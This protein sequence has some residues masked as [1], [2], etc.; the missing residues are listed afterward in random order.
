MPADPR[1][2]LAANA[3]AG[4]ATPPAPGRRPTLYVVA[5]SHLD[6]QWRWTLRD[7][8]RDFLP[9]T[10][11]ENLALFARFPGYVLSF[12]GAFRYQLLRD[13]YPAEWPRLLAAVA[14][15]RWHPAGAALEAFDCN[16]PA[17]ESIVRQ[18]LYGQAF[19]ERHFGRRCA[20]LFLPDCFG[21]PQILPTLAVH[22]GLRGFSSQKLVRNGL[23]RS[24]FGVPF[25]VGVWEG[26]DGSELLAALDPGGYG[27]PV[28]GDL[29]FDAEIE[30]QVA[31]LEQTGRPPVVFRYTG[32]GDKGGGLPVETLRWLER[33]AAPGARI[34]V[35]N[36][37]SERLFL[38]LA[39]AEIARLPRYRGELLLSVH[40]TGCY[41]S[42]AAM[43]RW[44]RRNEQLAA[45]AETAAVAASWLGA[46]PYPR[47]R[48]E[49]AWTRFLAHQMHDD[50]TG[51]S[52]PAAYR[53]SWR[54]EALAGNELAGVLAH[55]LAAVARGLDTRG[56]GR[57]LVVFN[58]LPIARQEL[59]EVPLPPALAEA[60]GVEAFDDEERPLATQRTRTAA[61]EPAV[62][63]R[64]GVPPLSFSVLFLVATELGTA[65][66]ATALGDGA[67]VRAQVEGLE[68]D[69][70]R[71]ELDRDGQVAQLFDR[72]LDR[73]ILAAPVRLELLADRS[74]KFPA[75]EIQHRDLVA[76]PRALARAL[77]PARV[78][79]SGPLRGTLEL[80]L[81][82][83]GSRCRQRL[84]LVAAGA[85][86]GLEVENELDWASRGHLL[87]A[88]FDLAVERAVGTWDLGLGWIERGVAS[89]RL[90]EVPAQQW[91]GLAAGD[92]T[93]GAAIAVDCKQ[94]WDRPAS[95]TLRLSLVRTPRVGR[96][97]RPQGWQDIG[98]HR[99]TWRLL[100]HAG[101]GRDG[102]L[103]RAAARLNQ[104][105]RG[106]WVEPHEGRFGRRLSL[107]SVEPPSAM[108]Q[109]LKLAEC[110]EEWIARLADLTGRGGTVR[111][112]IVAA[113]EDARAVDGCERTPEPLAATASDASTSPSHRPR[114]AV[115]RLG[116]DS[117]A[118]DLPPHGLATAALRVAPPACGPLGLPTQRTWPLPFDR[119][120]TSANGERADP[121]FDDRGRAIPAE[122]FPT[123]LDWGTIRFAL[124]PG[125]GGPNALP[126]R[127]QR[128]SLPEVDA[129][130]LFVLAASRAGERRAAFRADEV[131]LP[132]L[133][134]DWTTLAGRWDTLRRTPLAPWRRR[135]ER[136]FVR[137]LPVAWIG[138]HRHDRAGRDVAWEPCL[139]FAYR[140]RLPAGA[141]WLQLPDDP[142]IALFAATF[143]EPAAAPLAPLAP[144]FD[145]E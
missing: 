10:L 42:Q 45:A 44:N 68:S 46:Q 23:L 38:D 15:G 36:V 41:T 128:L 116:S 77:A 83:G 59:L 63:V 4:A 79:E 99:F 57:P 40:A 32:I 66:P 51:T 70:W 80:A 53:L 33:A 107:L 20:D 91:A 121:G 67:V 9:A 81:A 69:R 135:V 98:R 76:P 7:T 25:G 117:V 111:L 14:V 133:V 105:L 16:L 104:P 129:L 73:S 139:L 55:S 134:H 3:A 17:P 142:A 95:G 97:F 127:G 12:E 115:T 131:L 85:D 90:Y 64:V 87:K 65:A 39:P 21:F 1:P 96:R 137:S 78:V 145:R 92:G 144:L 89:E 54:D 26:P 82:V 22:C 126:C 103:A 114:A 71:V 24:A 34:A 28:T 112:Q 101:D 43:K 110:G 120:A 113:V 143:A 5:V 132:Q 141:A 130:D 31:E 106:F 49:G 60:A 58:P 18:I 108:L 138:H 19:F 88:R 50:L 61:G 124:G 29:R 93:W 35:R 109:A 122:L 6:S 27:D 100:A 52:I 102:T 74:F 37:A 47:Q 94:G 136:G 75:W 8:I 86:R 72:T 119:R 48:L 118:I 123:E 13:H 30:R 62:L 140:L 11:R 125:A 2:D 56:P 84:S